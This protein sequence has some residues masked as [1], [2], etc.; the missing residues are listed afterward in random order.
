MG[1]TLQELRST[2]WQ[3]Q[4]KQGDVKNKKWS[5]QKMYMPDPWT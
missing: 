5:S 3:L 1:G 4:N 2:S